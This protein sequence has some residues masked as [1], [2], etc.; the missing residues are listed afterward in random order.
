MHRILQALR[1]HF[2]VTGETE[3]AMEAASRDLTREYRRF[4]AAEGVRRTTS[5][6]SL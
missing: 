3:V 6:C 1:R 2:P 5:A 4:L